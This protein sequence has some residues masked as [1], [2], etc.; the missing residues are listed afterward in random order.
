MLDEDS[1]FL[2]VCPSSARD[3]RCRPKSAPARA[4]VRQYPPRGSC[5]V[6]WVCRKPDQRPLWRRSRRLHTNLGCSTFQTHPC[7][8]SRCFGANGVCRSHPGNE[9]AHSLQGTGKHVLTL[10]EGKARFTR[11]DGPSWLSRFEPPCGRAGFSP[12]AVRRS[13]KV[14]PAWSDPEDPALGGTRSHF[15]G[16]HRQSGKVAQ[17]GR[18]PC[19][20]KPK[21]SLVQGSPAVNEPC[22]PPTSCGALR[23]AVL[24][25]RA[26]STQWASAGLREAS[27]QGLE[28]GRESR[29]EHGMLAGEE[30]APRG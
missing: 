19:P 17:R 24:C 18:L 22:I 11:S 14:T 5:R 29:R 27:G 15:L 21:A 12:R 8:R 13:E 3:D 10:L 23:G 16:R 26:S 30:K 2:T 20:E 6:C 9:S 7:G 1:L 25:V 4:A 28:R